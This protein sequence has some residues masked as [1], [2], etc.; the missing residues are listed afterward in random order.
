MPGTAE[1]QQSAD[2]IFPPGDDR[3]MFPAVF[4]LNQRKCAI[5]TLKL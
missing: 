1:N 3:A 4:F 5:G 2:D